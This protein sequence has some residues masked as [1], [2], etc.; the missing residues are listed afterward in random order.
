[1]T[2]CKRVALVVVIFVCVYLCFHYTGMRV[3]KTCLFADVDDNI[4]LLEYPEIEITE[5]DKEWLDTIVKLEE[6]QKVF[7]C[8]E[9]LR[10]EFHLSETDLEDFYWFPRNNCSILVGKELSEGADDY[11]Y[12]FVTFESLLR[13]DKILKYVFSASRNRNCEFQY[14][15][16]LDVYKANSESTMTFDSLMAK[17]HNIDGTFWTEV[18]GI[19]LVWGDMTLFTFTLPRAEILNQ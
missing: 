8:T 12:V 9:N 16:T 18:P 10:R 5:K 1:M 14:T 4:V 2:K 17:Y 6:S 19:C 15:K 3:W 13:D 11:E 7:A